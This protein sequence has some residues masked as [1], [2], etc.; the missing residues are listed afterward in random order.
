MDSHHSVCAQEMGVIGPNNQLPKRRAGRG[1][2]GLQSQ[3]YDNEEN[4]LPDDVHVVTPRAE[5]RLPLKEDSSNVSE[6]LSLFPQPKSLLTR[7][8]QV[9]TSSNR[10]RVGK[11]HLFLR[12]QLISFSFPYF[13]SYSVIC[14]CRN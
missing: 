13:V 14:H 5:E 1:K 6:A 10:I 3:L 4:C 8:V 12:S 7:V 2:G 9:A 11:C